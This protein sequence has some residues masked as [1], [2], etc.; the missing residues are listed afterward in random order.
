MISGKA[1][2]VGMAHQD[3]WGTPETTLNRFLPVTARPG[4]KAKPNY[5]YPQELRKTHDRRYSKI[6][7]GVETGGDVKMTC[8][9][10]GGLEDW[11]FLTFGE[12]E[13][14]QEGSTAAY[15]HAYSRGF[16]AP[17][18]TLGIGYQSLNMETFFN[19]IVRSL[20]LNF[21]PNNVIDLTA[22]LWGSFGGISQ[23]EVASPVYGTSRPL[24]APGVQMTL[25][26]SVNTDITQCKVKIDRGTIRKGVLARGLESWKGNYNTMDVTGQ[27]T[28]LFNNWDEVEYF[29]GAT[30]SVNFSEDNLITGSARALQ[31]ETLGQ[32]IVPTPPHRDTLLLDMPKI[33]YDAM[34]IQSPYDDLITMQFDWSATYDSAATKTISAAVKSTLTTIA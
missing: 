6:N 24:T 15:N 10:G 32:T 8:Y 22:D 4:L 16:N 26:G 18:A 34:E 20:E 21:Q 25:G 1:L 30:D 19:V 33:S 28:M 3:V 7:K 13:T 11:L 14:T 5:E 29:F 27:L 31:I 23:P 9:P 12:V 2:Y 17:Y